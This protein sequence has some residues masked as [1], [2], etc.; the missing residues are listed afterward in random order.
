[1]KFKGASFLKF[2]F[3]FFVLFFIGSGLQNLHAQAPI[4]ATPV[5]SV[6][7]VLDVGSERAIELKNM[8]TLSLDAASPLSVFPRYML[9][10][11]VELEENFNGQNELII[12]AQRMCQLFSEAAGVGETNIGKVIKPEFFQEEN[13]FLT[14]E[15]LLGPQMIC[16][17]GLL[18]DVVIQKIN[19]L[20]Y[21]VAFRFNSSKSTMLTYANVKS[22]KT[23]VREVVNRQ[24][25]QKERF[26]ELVVDGNPVQLAINSNVLEF[27]MTRNT[28]AESISGKLLT[29]LVSNQAL[30]TNFNQS[31]KNL[32]LALDVYL[33]VKAINHN[34]KNSSVYGNSQISRILSN[35]TLYSFRP[36]SSKIDMRNHCCPV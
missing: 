22:Y 20:E 4:I 6:N 19:D 17:N 26:N 7:L 29:Q 27:V 30:L 9:R 10:S 15:L 32:P 12:S 5:D 28:A 35:Y 1:M 3:H 8:K 33:A 25:R 16:G 18:R 21:R 14:K 13:V 24:T 23:V 34:F 11:L 36:V 31:V 2:N